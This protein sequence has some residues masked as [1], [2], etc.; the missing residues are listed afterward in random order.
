MSF[1]ARKLYINCNDSSL[2]VSLQTIPRSITKIIS[3]VV[4]PDHN[5]LKCKLSIDNSTYTIRNDN[6]SSF[7]VGSGSPVDKL[8]FYI[9]SLS[10]SQLNLIQKEYLRYIEDGILSDGFI[11]G[12]ACYLVLCFLINND[13]IPD[14]HLS[15]P[16]DDIVNTNMFTYITI[17]LHSLSMSDT[18]IS[19]L[20]SY[21]QSFINIWEPLFISGPT[22]KPQYYAT[23]SIDVISAITRQVHSQLHTLQQQQYAL[24]T[25]LNSNLNTHHTKDI[26]HLHPNNIWSHDTNHTDD[27]NDNCS[28]IRRFVDS[29]SASWEMTA[30]DYDRLLHNS[31]PSSSSSS[32]SS[33]SSSSTTTK[34][35][36]DMVAHIK[37]AIHQQN[38]YQQHNV[39][40]EIHQ[41]I[42]QVTEVCNVIPVTKIIPKRLPAKKPWTN[43]VFR[44]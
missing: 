12:L 17:A 7:L 22:I 38:I 27:T 20:A 40:Q 8:S 11:S 31:S 13:L 1:V 6:I 36:F 16:H 21:V 2:S 37:K 15:I 26:H 5:S 44:K 24:Y 19:H 3:I 18:Y 4:V 28:P 42:Q 35:S 34:D 23:L 10:N 41:D 30:L 32:P 25:A 39:Q 33:S 29:D 9:N 14:Y 43:K